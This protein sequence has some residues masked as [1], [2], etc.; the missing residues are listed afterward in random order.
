[1][2]QHYTVVSYDRRG[3]ARSPLDDPAEQQHVHVHSDDAALLL[4]AVG[5][6]SPAWVFGASAGAVIGL[7]LVDRHPHQVRAL[8]AHEP[9]LVGLLPAADRPRPGGGVPQAALDQDPAAALTRFQEIIGVD[10]DDHEP[11]VELPR[12]AD[13][14]RAIANAKF[15]L[16]RELPMLQRYTPDTAAL[17]AATADIVPAGGTSDRDHYLHR[18]A[19][20]LADLLD[21]PLAEF[22][23]GHAGFATHPRGFA[24]RLHRLLSHTN[25]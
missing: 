13:T 2:A 16:G 3:Y 18:C 22:P 14:A 12:F 10:L 20:A 4:Q 25:A 11:G 5:R 9:P 7:D 6:G 19:A 17:R 15:F 23:G 24:D 8:V 21:L 1:L